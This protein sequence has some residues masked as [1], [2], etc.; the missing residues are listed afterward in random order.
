MTITSSTVLNRIL[1]KLL[2]HAASEYVD[3]RI[4]SLNQIFVFIQK[5]YVVG[6]IILERNLIKIALHFAAPKYFDK[7]ELHTSV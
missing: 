7:E 1:S 3:G 4:K 2:F 5:N 6:R